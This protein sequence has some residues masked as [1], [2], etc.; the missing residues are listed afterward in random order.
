VEAWD[1]SGH[2]LKLEVDGWAAAL[3][4]HEVDHLNGRLFLDRLI[5]PAR[6]DLVLP[7]EYAQYRRNKGE[8]LH[9]VDV[10]GRV[11]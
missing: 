1:R 3:L 11:R 4:Q 8:W 7:T 6:A 9:K 5:E 2:E 10:S